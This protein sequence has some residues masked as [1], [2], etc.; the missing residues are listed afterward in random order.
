MSR[1]YASD[2]DEAAREKV[3]RLVRA[4]A[5]TVDSDGKFYRNNRFPAYIYD[6]LAG[7]LID[8]SNYAHVDSAVATLRKATQAA[9][10]YLPPH[11]M[12][13]NEHA[14]PGEDF[15]QHAWDESYTLPENQFQAWQMTG[16]R[17]HLQLGR[18]FLYDEF[19]AALARGDNALPGKHAY[20]HVNALSSAARA[21]L[22]LGNPMYLA[23]AQHLLHA[24][25]S[26]SAAR[27]VPEAAADVAEGARVHG[28]IP[29][30]RQRPR[31][32]PGDSGRLHRR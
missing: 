29:G 5:A 30:V 25:A 9:T 27:G 26:R 13:R 20:S 19:F 16:K 15:S 24:V 12:P 22:S 3:Q 18:R 28:P 32:G 1:Y 23:A 8:A 31:P 7:G 21:Y 2:G 17:I 10:P 11:A 6:K 4:F 14:Q